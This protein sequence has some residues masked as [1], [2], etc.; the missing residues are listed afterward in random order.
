MKSGLAFWRARRSRH[1]EDYTYESSD[2]VLG[3]AGSG[4]AEVV[5]QFRDACRK[6]ED[7]FESI[8]PELS[9]EEAYNVYRALGD[10]LGELQELNIEL[11]NDI[12]SSIGS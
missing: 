12:S 2:R 7:E 11:L 8:A 10:L 4:A 9:E 6:F 1:Y 5:S 3:E